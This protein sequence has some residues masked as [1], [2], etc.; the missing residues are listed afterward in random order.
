M[1]L[2]CVKNEIIHQTSY[3]HLNK[4]ELLNVNIDFPYVARIM[5]IYMSVPKYLWFDAVLSACHLINRMSS[6]FLGK[7]FVL[8]SLS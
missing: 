1:S 2:F 3:S 7:G 8:L 4:M 5:M 6:V